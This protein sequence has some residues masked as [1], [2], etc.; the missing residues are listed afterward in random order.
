MDTQPSDLFHPPSLLRMPW[1]EGLIHPAQDERRARSEGA[2]A[3]AAS[4]AQPCG[5]PFRL[6]LYRQ[7][8]SLWA[9]GE[10][11]GA[12][13]FPDGTAL[14]GARRG[15]KALLAAPIVFVWR[16]THDTTPPDVWIQGADGLMRSQRLEEAGML[17]SNPKR[18]RRAAEPQEGWERLANGTVALP[19]WGAVQARRTPS[20]QQTLNTML[21]VVLDA[22]RIPTFF[23]YGSHLEDSTLQAPRLLTLH[24]ADDRTAQASSILTPFLAAALGP[25]WI[26]KLV[27]QNWE[28]V[29]GLVASPQSPTSAHD[30]LCALRHHHKLWSA[31]RA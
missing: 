19:P 14:L 18:W 5:S 9:G 22:T 6:R 25:A 4:D 21:W 2:R 27:D 11:Y 29:P 20:E 12:L 30:R 24:R 10:E 23:L 3:L 15:D 8:R 13:L 31:L 16:D 26:I 28:G 17:A 7:D 1:L